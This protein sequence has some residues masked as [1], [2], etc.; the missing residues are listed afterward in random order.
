MGYTLF[1]ANKNYSSW[2][3]R[4]WILMRAF[5][6]PFEEKIFKFEQTEVQAAFSDFSPTGKVPCLHDLSIGDKGLAIWD[7]LSIIEY[8]AERES[9][10][11]VWPAEVAARAFAR[12]ACA[13]IHSGF[14]AIRNELGMNVGVRVDIGEPSK[15]LKRDLERLDALWTEGLTKFGG[16][17]LA[18]D[19]F[20]AADAFYAPVATRLQTYGIKLSEPSMAYAKRLL[21]LPASKEW[22]EAGIQETWRDEGHDK[23]TLGG[24]RKLLA[25]YRKAA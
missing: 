12:C 11:G 9:G 14:S 5:D 4:P 25:D 19:K 21:E 23:E 18:G 3:M 1:I 2:S 17:W 6:I 13:E 20:S 15:A 8:L 24:G 22:I 10:K 16:P 7:S